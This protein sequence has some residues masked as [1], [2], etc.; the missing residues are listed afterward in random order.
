MNWPW[1][2]VMLMR[3][4][5]LLIAMSYVAPFQMRVGAR[6]ELI[7]QKR[8]RTAACMNAQVVDNLT[9]GDAERKL[10][11]DD[12]LQPLV[13]SISELWF[14]SMPL[15]TKPPQNIPGS[16]TVVFTVTANGSVEGMRLL[17]TRGRAPIVRG[18]WK[19]IGDG[20]PNRFPK[21]LH[22]ESLS[23]RF[24]FSVNSNCTP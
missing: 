13:D 5:S 23:L 3:V 15:E 12:V 22:R 2:Y 6:Q 17:N 7:S 21:A 1:R 16:A 11:N 18:I 9:S 19:A 24:E 20:K 4:G 14:S 10:I 8:T